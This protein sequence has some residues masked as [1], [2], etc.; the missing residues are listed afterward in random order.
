MQRPAPWCRSYIIDN[1]FYAPLGFMFGLYLISLKQQKA[2]RDSQGI[3]RHKKSTRRDSNPRPSPW[4]GDTPPL[5]HSCILLF[6]VCL[7]LRSLEHASHIIH[8]KAGIVNI[9]LAIFLLFFRGRFVPKYHMLFSLAKGLL[10][11]K[12]QV[13]NLSFRYSTPHYGVKDLYKEI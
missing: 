1:W 7:V 9:F 8:Y 2:L 4:Q 3:F 11:K 5:S 13:H 12:G 6:P 10:H